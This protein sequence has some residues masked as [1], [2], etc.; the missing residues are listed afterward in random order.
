MDPHYCI[1]VSR[2][3][4]DPEALIHIRSSAVQFMWNDREVRMR[5]KRNKCSE[6]LRLTNIGAPAQS[7]EKG[8]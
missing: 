8:S 6:W 2:Q 5:V 7:F 3:T 4:D 1:R